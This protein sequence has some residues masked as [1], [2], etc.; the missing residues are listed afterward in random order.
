MTESKADLI[1]IRPYLP[2]DENFI[3]GTWLNG[4]FFGNPLYQSLMDQASYYLKYRK[5]IDRILAK[6]ETQIRVAALKETPDVICAYAVI[7]G[8]ILHWIFCKPT[9]RKYGLAKDLVSKKK[10]KYITHL[11][12]F[13]L[14]IKP[15]S[16]V[17][18][19][20]LLQEQ[21]KWR[22]E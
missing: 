14:F 16:W 22:S 5:I 3:Y 6:P 13:G 20:Y 12:K 11:T 19:P 18:D 15:K 9:F 21:S 4:L 7:E 1:E 8:K 17:Y 2:A 10:I